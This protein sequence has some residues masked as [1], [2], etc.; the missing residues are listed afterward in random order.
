MSKPKL[1][2]LPSAR[3][4]ALLARE[5]DTVRPGH[6][7]EGLLAPTTPAELGSFVRSAL[8]AKTVGGLIAQARQRRKESLRG[9]AK[10]VGASHPRVLELERVGSRVEVQTLARYA[11]ALGYDLRLTFVPRDGGE[12]IVAEVVDVSS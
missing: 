1:T 4:A 11:A 2:K 6:P 12:E 9:L 3:L 7:P 10:R 8:V 5:E